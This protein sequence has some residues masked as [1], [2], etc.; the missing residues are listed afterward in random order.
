M[1][2]AAKGSTQTE[3]LPPKPTTSASA[4]VTPGA[5]EST[6]PAVIPTPQPTETLTQNTEATG[7][8]AEYNMT[9][10]EYQQIVDS[11]K[12]DRTAHPTPESALAAFNAAMTQYFN[13]GH[14]QADHT[15][16]YEWSAPN[17]APGWNSWSNEVYSSAIQEGMF[18]K[19]YINT[20]SN[21]ISKM[22]D[23]K[24]EANRM[25]ANTNRDN[26]PDYKIAFNLVAKDGI[27]VFDNGGFIAYGDI[28]Y[29]DNA[30]DNSSTA[31]D[32]HAIGTYTIPNES[33]AMAPDEQTNTWRV[34][35]II[36]GMTYG[37]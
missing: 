37:K 24:L 12:I 13:G 4:P 9:N 32:S 31:T 28:V 7:K 21:Y 11:F 29:T 25:W 14:T 34:T 6:T 27:K 22:K 18:D 16:H 1:N 30:A 2:S 17:V 3:T 35:R 26:Q 20:D 19:G 8:A 10:A 15:K 23:L 36:G 33:V 5:K